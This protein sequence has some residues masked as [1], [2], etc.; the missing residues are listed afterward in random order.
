MRTH[1]CISKFAAVVVW[2]LSLA[3]G[4]ATIWAIYLYINAAQE[5]ISPK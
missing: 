4:A 1:S 5:P 3:C 2:V